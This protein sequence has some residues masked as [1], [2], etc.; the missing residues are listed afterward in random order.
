MSPVAAAPRRS[1]ARRRPPRHPTQSHGAIPTPGGPPAWFSP[2]WRGV[3][4]EVGRGPHQTC[5]YTYGLGKMGGAKSPFQPS[6]PDVAVLPCQCGRSPSDD[7]TGPPHHDGGGA[8]PSTSAATLGGHCCEGAGR[9]RATP[10]RGEH[11][12]FSTPQRSV[13]ASHFFSAAASPMVATLTARAVHRPTWARAS[14]TG[15]AAAAAGKK[16]EWWHSSRLPGGS[17]GWWW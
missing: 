15:T 4:G 7:A 8:P 1:G 16:R 14:S 5:G 2:L 9:G 17:P 3:L 11:E 13:Y 6:P 12:V 10:R